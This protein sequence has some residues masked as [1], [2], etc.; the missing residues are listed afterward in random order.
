MRPEEGSA[1][2]LTVEERIDQEC[3][4]LTGA[5]R[6][7]ERINGI[8]V[9]K[10]V[11]GKS[12]FIMTCLGEFGLASVLKCGDALHKLT[13]TQPGGILRRNLPFGCDE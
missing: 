10:H 9:R 5:L 12:N 13:P 2:R 11:A 8:R 7:L 4:R 6:A 1:T 3:L